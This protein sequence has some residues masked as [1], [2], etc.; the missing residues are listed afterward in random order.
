LAAGRRLNEVISAHH[1]DTNELLLSIPGIGRVT[2]ARI[3]LEVPH[4]SNFV[5][6]DHL[7]SYIGFVPDVHGSD[8]NVY[9]RGITY[10]RRVLL[11]SAFV[12][13]SWRAIGKDPAMGLAYS[14]Y[15]K[16]G[17]KPNNAIIRIARKLVNRVFFVLR[18]RKRY[19]IARVR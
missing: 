14:N 19:E 7:A 18:E 13:S 1:M 16:R 15:I 8:D 12:E 2:A 6:S 3:C 17:M 4:A 9:V 5:N 10:R 11:R